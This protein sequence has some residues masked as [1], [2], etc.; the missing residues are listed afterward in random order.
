MRFLGFVFSTAAA[1]VK[2]VRADHVEAAW[3]TLMPILTV[4]ENVA[5]TDFPNYAAGSW[6]PD[7]AVMLLARDGRNWWVPEFHYNEQRNDAT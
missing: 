2:I 6:G 3:A 1:A 7:S 4:W 5:P